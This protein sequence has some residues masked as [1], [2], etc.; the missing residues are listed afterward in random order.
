MMGRRPNTDWSLV[1]WSRSNDEIAASLGCSYSAVSNQRQ[2]WSTSTSKT[3]RVDWESVDWNQTNAVIARQVGL[4]EATVA[5]VRRGVG[6]PKSTIRNPLVCRIDWESADWFMRDTDIA[7]QLGCT[8]ERVRQM[9]TWLGKPKSPLHRR[10][11]ATFE[12]IACIVKA[13]GQPVNRKQLSEC[14]GKLVTRQQADRIE[15]LIGERIL[16]PPPYRAPRKYPYELWNWELS[17][18][19]LAKIWLPHIALRVARSNVGAIRGGGHLRGSGRQQRARWDLRIPSDKTNP[20]RVAAAEA[21][22]KKANEW[23][24]VQDGVKP[25][26]FLGDP[27]ATLP[28]SPRHAFGGIGL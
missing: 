21:E 3:I 16:E 14:R 25:L 17:D 19:D 23:R 13:N 12:T 7:R 9:R 1:D 27:S 4:C 20:E 15:P 10:R 22:M 8:K 28:S 18:T 2:R 5:R 26:Q 24:S 11:T 6:A